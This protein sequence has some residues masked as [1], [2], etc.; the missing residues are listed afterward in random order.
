MSEKFV[1]THSDIKHI[2]VNNEIMSN[3]SYFFKRLQNFDKEI[4]LNISDQE[5]Q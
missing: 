2:L 3:I 4:C 5:T 1:H